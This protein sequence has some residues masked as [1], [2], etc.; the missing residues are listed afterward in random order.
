MSTRKGEKSLHKEFVFHWE[1]NIAC[2]NT[3][4]YGEKV[5]LFRRILRKGFLENEHLQKLKV[6]LEKRLCS[7]ENAQRA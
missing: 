2:K 7:I 4:Q 1:Q 6:S 3:Q 5:I